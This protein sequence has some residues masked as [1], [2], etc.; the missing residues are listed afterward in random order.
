VM[1]DSKES[2][3]PADPLII[4]IPSSNCYPFPCQNLPAS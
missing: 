1:F 3:H 4:A 2:F